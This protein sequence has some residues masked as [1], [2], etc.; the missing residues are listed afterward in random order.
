MFTV[1]VKRARPNHTNDTYPPTPFP[2]KFGGYFAKYLAMWVSA[3]TGWSG[4]NILRL[5][6]S[7]IGSNR[8]FLIYH[9]QDSNIPLVPKNSF[10]SPLHQG[11]Q[12]GQ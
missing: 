11:S 12:N 5:D 3:W 7:S 2:K 9:C 4:V 6:D 1:S 8:C 10:I